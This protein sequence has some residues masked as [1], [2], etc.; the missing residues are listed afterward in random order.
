M[1][2]ARVEGGGRAVVLGLGNL[3]NRDEGVGVHALE[4]LRRRLERTSGIE[5]L[6]GGVLGLALLP[7][8]ESAG[9]LLVL[10]AVDARREPGALIELLGEDIPL[11]S[12]VKISWHQVTFQEVLQ[13]AQARGRLPRHLHLVGV[14]P[15][16]ISTGL[17]LSPVVTAALPELVDRAVK[18]LSS[19][20]LA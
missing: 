19:W 10:D 7:L 1:S 16:D 14:Q 2:S 5:I 3:L 4:P 8:V 20:G 17:V 18:V 9:S 13:L 11:F 12:Q 6:D 15:A